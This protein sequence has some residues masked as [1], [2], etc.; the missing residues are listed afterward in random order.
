[1]NVKYQLRTEKIKGIHFH[2]KRSWIIISTYN[3]N[4]QIIDFRVGSVLKQYSVSP[5]SVSP[6]LTPVH[7]ISRVPQH[8]AD[9][10]L[11]RPQQTGLPLRLQR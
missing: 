7:P 8:P 3:G 9:L 11:R 1:M 4:V 6:Q 5:E 10:R 2:P